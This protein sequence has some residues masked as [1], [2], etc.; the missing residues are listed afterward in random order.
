MLVPSLRPS[1]SR[2]QFLVSSDVPYVIAL[3]RGSARAIVAAGLVQPVVAYERIRGVDRAP[4]A[5]RCAAAVWFRKGGHVV[6]GVETL[7]W[8][9]RVS[10]TYK[11]QFQMR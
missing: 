9:L 1:S 2:I 8:G 7:G 6:V 4:E 10:N 11:Q 3:P 5:L